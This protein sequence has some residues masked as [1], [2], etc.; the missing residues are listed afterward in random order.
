MTNRA[1]TVRTGDDLHGLR[2]GSWSPSVS[3]RCRGFRGSSPWCSPTAGRSSRTPRKAEL[4]RGWGVRR[5]SR[6]HGDD[7]CDG[8]SGGR[9][10]QPGIPGRWPSDRLRGARPRP[11]LR[12]RRTPIARSAHSGRTA[13]H[14]RRSDPTASATNARANP[15][16]S[17]TKHYKG[18]PGLPGAVR[19]PNTNLRVSSGSARIQERL[20]SD[21]S[22]RHARRRTPRGKAGGLRLTF[23]NRAAADRVPDR[24]HGGTKR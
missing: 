15:A 9:A 19:E 8:P 24:E 17:P 4:G 12:P 11:E 1:S 21:A 14:T 23:P 3:C 2:V 6:D 10:H 18:W 20:R 7:L 16:R 13:S 22:D 5:R